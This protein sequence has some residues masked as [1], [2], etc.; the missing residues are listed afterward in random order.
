MTQLGLCICA[1]QAVRLGQGEPLLLLF[2]RAHP[3]DGVDEHGVV[4]MVGCRLVRHDRS[5]GK[6]VLVI[7]QRS[8]SVHIEEHW[9]SGRKIPTY[10]LTHIEDILVILYIYIP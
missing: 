8:M 9:L 4:Q 10:L 7:N 1:N 2:L 3:A 6:E 5:E